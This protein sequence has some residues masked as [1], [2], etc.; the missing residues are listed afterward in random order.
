LQHWA[1]VSLY[2]SSCELAET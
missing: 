2:T 1:G